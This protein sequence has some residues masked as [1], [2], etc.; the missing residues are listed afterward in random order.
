MV[1]LAGLLY[2]AVLGHS[3]APAVAVLAFATALGALRAVSGAAA[4]VG[5]YLY[6]VGELPSD[7]IGATSSVSAAGSNNGHHTLGEPGAEPS[8]EHGL[9]LVAMTETEE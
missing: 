4:A 9:V 1:T 2:F 8:A 3:R 5:G 6:A 7:L